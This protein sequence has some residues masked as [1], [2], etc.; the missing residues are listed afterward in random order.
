MRIERKRGSGALNS[1][2]GACMTLWCA[3]VGP[4]IGFDVEPLNPPMPQLKPSPRCL[5]SITQRLA[6]VPCPCLLPPAHRLLLTSAFF[7]LARQHDDRELVESLR[8]FQDELLLSARAA[9]PQSFRGVAATVDGGGASARPSGDPSSPDC[10]AAVSATPSEGLELPSSTLDGERKLTSGMSAASLAA[11]LELTDL[12]AAQQRFGGG[13]F[14]P[15]LPLGSETDSVERG[16]P[17]LPT[18]TL[19]LGSSI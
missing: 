17:T 1:F 16:L 19:R 15:I 12:E 7:P 5:H 2:K 6:L 4:A 14:L 13:T 9:A 10:R 11:A 8:R 18:S 3:P